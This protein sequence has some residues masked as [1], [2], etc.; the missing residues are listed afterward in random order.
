MVD[1][2]NDYVLNCLTDFLRTHAGFLASSSLR[3]LIFR[4]LD[5]LIDYFMN[6]AVICLYCG[7]K[8]FKV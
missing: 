2:L 4:L 1:R 3:N 8:V 7:L 5:W 6:Y